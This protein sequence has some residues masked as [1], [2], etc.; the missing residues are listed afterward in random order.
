MLALDPKTV[1]EV[2]EARKKLKDGDADCETDSRNHAEYGYADNADDCQPELPPLDPIDAA[3][4][5][6]FNKAY[7]C[8]NDDGSQ[9]RV[10]EILEQLG[11]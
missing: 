5:G 3:E 4:V 6:H 10:W 9:C 11:G 8:G 7:G 2:C 1:L